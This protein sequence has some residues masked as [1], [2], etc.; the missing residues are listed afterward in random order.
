M[1]PLG[2]L[3]VAKLLMTSGPAVRPARFLIA[4]LESPAKEPLFGLPGVS[5]FATVLLTFVLKKIPVALIA[6]LPEALAEPVT[7]WA[8]AGVVKTNMLTSDEVRIA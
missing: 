3:K 6:M 5:G 1:V 7:D 2:V 4:P 8:V